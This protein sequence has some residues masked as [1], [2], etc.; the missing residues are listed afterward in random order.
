MSDS[1]GVRRYVHPR[2]RGAALTIRAVMAAV[3]AALIFSLSPPAGSLEKVK[4]GE[5]VPDFSLPDTAGKTVNSADLTGKAAVLTFFK[6]GPN[7]SRTL[8]RIGRSHQANR[9]KEIAYLGIYLGDKK[10][11]EAKALAEKEGAAFPVLMGSYDVSATFGV[12]ILPTTVFV[13]Q[14]GIIIHAIHL[15]PSEL[16]EETNAY[17]LVALG[18]KTKEDVEMVLHPQEA[19]ALSEEEQK[20]RKFHTQAMIMMDRGLKDLAVK[21]LKAALELDPGFCDARL[22]LGHTYLDDGQVEEARA[23]FDYVIKCDP[24]SNEAKVGLGMVHARQ[25]EL[26]QAVEYFQSALQ[27]NPYPERAYYELGR[28]YEKQG[29]LAQAVESYKK[30]LKRLLGNQ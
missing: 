7:T 21:K 13:D 2:S 16:E 19:G 26:E 8:K 17:A 9:E 18:E 30:A 29:D 27:L 5:K 28:V 1:R 25:G 22:L 3:S 10:P 24:T 14:A 12:K 20:A 4:I 15:A 6:G 23:E 11:E